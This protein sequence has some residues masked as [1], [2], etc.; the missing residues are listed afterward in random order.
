MCIFFNKNFRRVNILPFCAKSS[1]RM[2]KNQQQQQ[3]QQRQM[4]HEQHQHQQHLVQQEATQVMQPSPRQTQ[5]AKV[6]P[7]PLT[8]AAS[9]IDNRHRDGDL[10][11]M[12]MTTTTT[13]QEFE[14]KSNTS[15]RSNNN[16]DD[17]T[18]DMEP[19]PSPVYVARGVS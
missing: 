10:M 18:N 1:L 6:V 12:M 13:N 8:T 7:S 5:L 14:S 3:M 15:N 19:H 16:D 11:V 2:K 17:A 9:S 4:Q